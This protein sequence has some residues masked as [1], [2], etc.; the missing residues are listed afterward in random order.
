MTTTMRQRT[1]LAAATGLLALTLSA[2][3]AFAA[4]PPEGAISGTN[5]NDILQG[6]GLKDNIVGNKGNDILSGRGGNDLLF[7]GTAQPSTIETEP[8]KISSTAA[9]VTTSS[10][11]ARAATY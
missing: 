3:T 2:G 4:G 6:S 7:G 11:V 5:G 10:T 9:T 1:V 8:A